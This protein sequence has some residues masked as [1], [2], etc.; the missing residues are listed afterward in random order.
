M[1]RVSSRTR[2]TE[3][4]ALR[5]QKEGSDDEVRED[6]PE[7]L[8]LREVIPRLPGDVGVLADAPQIEF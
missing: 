4:V 5:L 2:S 3:D 7:G 6:P 8:G 1:S